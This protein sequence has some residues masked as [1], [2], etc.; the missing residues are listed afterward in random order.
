[1]ML[2]L[3]LSVCVCMFFVICKT[4]GI[5]NTDN[6]IISEQKSHFSLVSSYISLCSKFL[7]IYLDSTDFKVSNEL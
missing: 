2:H 3:S 1:M 4:E 6:K 7:P 5:D